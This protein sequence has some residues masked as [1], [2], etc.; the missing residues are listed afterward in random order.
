MLQNV[1]LKILGQP[2]H[3]GLMVTDARYKIYKANEDRL[4]FKHFVQ[5]IFAETGSVKYYQILSPKQLFKKVLRSLHGEF[6]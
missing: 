2:H 1:K 3:E 4:I 6:G 5:E